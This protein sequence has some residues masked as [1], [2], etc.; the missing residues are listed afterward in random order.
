MKDTSLNLLRPNRVEELQ[1]DL[2][3]QRAAMNNPY[4]KEK[5]LVTKEIR[6]TEHLLNTYAPEPLEA[7]EKD[8][9]R[10]Q[11]QQLASE[12]QE[13]MLTR[14]EM[15]RGRNG[16]SAAHAHLKWETANKKKI[17]KWKNI[18]CQ[19]N[20]DGDPNFANIEQLRKEGSFVYDAN[21]LMPGVHAM[22]PQ[23]KENFP[24]DMGKGVKSAVAHH[25]T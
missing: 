16:M 1:E 7:K 18:R 14:Q 21:A 11:E 2:I 22:S 4:L 17:L 8:L 20:E 23:A 19:L 13:G 5:G 24:P 25:A 3:R 9:L 15:I 6:K 12:I 10:K